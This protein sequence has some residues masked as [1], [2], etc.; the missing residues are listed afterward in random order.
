MARTTPLDPELL[1]LARSLRSNATSAERL[2][3]RLLRNRQLGG[4]KFRRQHPLGPYVLDFYCAEARL[5]IEI[6]GGQHWSEAEQQRDVCR[7]RYLRDRGIAVMRFSNREVLSE[8]QGVLEVVW[9]RLSGHAR[10]L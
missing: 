2:M 8:T 6:D 10:E 5:A 9:H 4:F 1:K 7:T 3:W